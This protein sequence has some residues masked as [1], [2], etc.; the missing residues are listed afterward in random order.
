MPGVYAI[1][2]YSGTGNVVGAL[3]GRAVVE[4]ITTGQSQAWSDFSEAI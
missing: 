2:A 1:G 4:K 3:L